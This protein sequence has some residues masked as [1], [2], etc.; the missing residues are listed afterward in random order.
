MKRSPYNSD[1]PSPVKATRVEFPLITPRPGGA[2]GRPLEKAIRSAIESRFN[3]DFSKVRVHTD[4]E[5]ARSARSI[6]AQAYTV[7]DDVVFGRGAYRPDSRQGQELLTHELAHVAQQGRAG[8]TQ[9]A[10]TRADRA[11][12]HVMRGRSVS[13]YEL[14]GAPIGLQAKPDESSKSRSAG[15]VDVITGADAD[16]AAT[17][18]TA[19][20]LDRFVRDGAELTK[21][22]LDAIDQ[23]AFSIWLNLSMYPNATASIAISGHTDTTGREKHNSGLGTARADSAKA[24]LE[25]ARQKQQID[26]AKL[27][28]VTTS[29]LGETK[30]RVATGD[31]VDEPRNRR[32]EI[33]VTIEVKVPPQPKS[34]TRQPL[35]GTPGGPKIWEVPGIMEELDPPRPATG[36]RASKNKGEGLEEA[37]KR[38]PLLKQLPKWARDKAIGALKDADEK[39]AEAIIDAIPFDDEY[40]QAAKA[41]MKALLQTLKGRKFKPPPSPPPGMPEIAPPSFPKAPGEMIF[42]LPPIRF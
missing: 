19:T 16:A 26:P 25:A 3:H 20:V 17:E 11:V 36:P 23:L 35:P 37:L 13:P 42:K 12:A 18:P 29:S 8:S 4:Q 33:E 21:T 6:G 41:A 7:G 22:H 14:G 10:E 27:D 5:A 40:K 32:V 38:D 24:A 15:E 39:A 9:D 2:S 28:A 1:S 30:L 31:E 34:P